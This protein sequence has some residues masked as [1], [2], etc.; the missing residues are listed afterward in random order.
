MKKTNVKIQNWN[1]DI[2]EQ[3]RMILD[4]IAAGKEHNDLLLEIPF[5]ESEEEHE[6]L[7][8]MTDNIALFEHVDR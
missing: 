6:P 4:R 8:G 1:V 5:E 2:V 3:F 7:I